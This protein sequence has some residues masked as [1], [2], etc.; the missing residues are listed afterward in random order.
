MGID[1]GG[2]GAS[3]QWPRQVAGRRLSWANTHTVL[4]AVAV[5]G[6]TKTARVENGQSQH[7]RNA[8]ND[9]RRKTQANLD[10]LTIGRHDK[11]MRDVALAVARRKGSFKMVM[12]HSI[13][14]ARSLVDNEKYGY[15]IIKSEQ[16]CCAYPHAQWSP[17]V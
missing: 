17:S 14:L 12:H 4:G 10:R 11:L 6:A 13:D 1:L 3:W 16:V 9:L 15:F 7:I 8:V 2:P 5:P